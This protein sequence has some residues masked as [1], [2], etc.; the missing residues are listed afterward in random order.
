MH[1][2]YL[3]SNSYNTYILHTK[4][5]MHTYIHLWIDREGWVPWD[6]QAVNAS[7]NVILWSRLSTSILVR[8]PGLYRFIYV[9]MYICIYENVCLWLIRIIFVYVYT[10][11]VLHLYIC[12]E[13]LLI[14]TYIHI[15]KNISFPESVW[16]CLPLRKC[17]CL[18]TWTT[19]P[20]Y[21]YSHIHHHVLV[22]LLVVQK[23]CLS[24]P[25]L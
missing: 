16:G 12:I 3:T 22:V 2:T 19:S 17:L 14:H 9:C 20:S 18:S 25:R 23:A 11:F 5:Y 8:V 10:R 24:E 6:V 21:S 13:P 4:L 1:R 7:P 15:Y